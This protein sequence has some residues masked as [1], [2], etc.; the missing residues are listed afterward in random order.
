MYDIFTDYLLSF[1]LFYDIM[2]SCLTLLSTHVYVKV[3]WYETL[4]DCAKQSQSDNFLINKILIATRKIVVGFFSI[5]A[6]N[7]VYVYNT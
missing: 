6:C 2:N 4:F 5:V 3:D 1:T 7:D